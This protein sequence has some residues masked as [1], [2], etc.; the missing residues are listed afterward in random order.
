MLFFGFDS[1]SN[2]RNFN[3]MG[4]VPIRVQITKTINNTGL[5]FGVGSTP[6]FKQFLMP[7][8]FIFKIID[9]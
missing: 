3:F 6:C 1:G 7:V 9:F 4:L 5:R 2:S 8:L